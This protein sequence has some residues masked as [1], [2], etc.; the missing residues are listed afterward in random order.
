MWYQLLTEEMYFHVFFILDFLNRSFDECIIESE[1]SRLEDFTKRNRHLD[2]EK[3]DFIQ[4][5][6]PHSL[7]SRVLSNPLLPTILV[8]IGISQ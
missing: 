1:V 5:R 7:R 4:S 6:G 8:K 3:L 2:D